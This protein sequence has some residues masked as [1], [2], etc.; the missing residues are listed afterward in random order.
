[1]YVDTFTFSIKCLRNFTVA[2]KSFTV[3]KFNHTTFFRF[4]ETKSLLATSTLR[5]GHTR[6][7]H[8][9]NLKS[10]KK[11]KLNNI[12]TLLKCTY[13]DSR[14]MSE[15]IVHV[16]F[17]QTTATRWDS[18]MKTAQWRIMSG[19]IVHAWYLVSTFTQTT[20]MCVNEVQNSAVFT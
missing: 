9:Q 18:H 2:V 17:T 10:L 20:A 4:F 15:A 13:G 19:D 3:I 6:N 16:S 11:E 12:S 1:M 7:E 8:W 5:T 14:I